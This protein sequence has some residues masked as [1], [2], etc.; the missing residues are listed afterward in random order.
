MNMKQEYR[1]ICAADSRELQELIQ[2]W[3][4]SHLKNGGPAW[5][6][7]GGPVLDKN[8]YPMQAVTRWVEVDR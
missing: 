8:G 5:Q 3:L 7:Q 6:C 4:E 1:V 2:I